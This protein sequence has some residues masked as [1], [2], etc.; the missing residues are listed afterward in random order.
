MVDGKLLL[1]PRTID[2]IFEVQGQGA[3]LVLGMPLTMGLG[4]GLPM[5]LL[6][7]FIPEGKI[8]FWGGWGGSL[9]VVDVGRRMTVAYMM[10]KM[11]PGLV[12]GPNCAAL[13]G[14]LYGILG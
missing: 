3:D 1:S 10:N 11:A 7:P 2:S 13:I 6:L 14:A 12:G 4:Y 9:V 5:P 8:C